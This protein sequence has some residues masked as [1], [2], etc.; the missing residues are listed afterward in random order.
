M[1]AE[2]SARAPGAARVFLSLLM[3]DV[4]VVR[5]EIVPFLART[6]MQPLMFTIIFGYVMPKMRFMKAGYTA[7]LLPGVLA[8]S[9]ALGA[10][11]SVAL[12]MVA[13]F[14]FTK[15]I[16]DRLLA[17]IPIWLV[18]FEKVVAGALQALIAALFVLPLARLIM[19]PIPGLSAEYLP[20][21]V[22]VIVF[23]AVAFS[24][25]GLFLGC[26]VAA[27]QIGLLFGVIVA[28]M[29]MFGCAYYPWRGLDAIPAMKV[30][31]LINPLTYIAEGLRAV[32]VPDLPH[33][34]LP[35]VLG[36]LTAIT[37]I[38]WRLGLRAFLKRAIG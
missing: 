20:L 27:P 18:A 22:V 28:P 6:A 26:I 4:V 2:A 30:A 23:G 1:T 10:V 14:G 3:R 38:F 12:P 11:Q 34:P 5:R 9:L 35:V 15:E 33:M 37:L 25:L 7:A 32:L 8:V 13:D 19:G 16:E 36:A 17:P 31:V 29:I 24:M 21:V